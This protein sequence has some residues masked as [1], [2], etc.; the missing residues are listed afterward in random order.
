MEMGWTGVVRTVAVTVMVTSAAWVTAGAWWLQ[1]SSHWARETRAVA[2]AAQGQPAVTS[3]TQLSELIGLQ[4]PVQAPG[5]AKPGTPLPAAISYDAAAIGPLKVPVRGIVPGQLV[6][7]FS[8]ARAGGRLHDAIDIMA[9]RGTPV[10]AAA[11][12]TVERLFYSN[13]GGL[14]V[15]IRSPDR[16]LIYYYAHLEGFA[17]GLAERQLL[18]QGDPIGAVGSTGNADPAAPHLHFAI[19]ATTP[20]RKWYEATSPINPYPLLVKAQ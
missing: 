7:T 10:V 11:Q 4:S 13:G 19:L 16:R 2:A 14:T 17:P 12:G 20:E 9:P 15:Y 3:G 6:D 5:A 18:R 8:Q 1:S